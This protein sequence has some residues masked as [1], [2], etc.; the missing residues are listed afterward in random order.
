[1]AKKY[2][3]KNALDLDVDGKIIL[4]YRLGGPELDPSGSG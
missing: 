1:L 4:K 2:E 3:V